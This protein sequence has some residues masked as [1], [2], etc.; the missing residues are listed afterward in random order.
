MQSQLSAAAADN[1]RLAQEGA[2]AVR[3]LAAA[4]DVLQGGQQREQQLAA[5]LAAAVAQC[6]GV[7]RELAGLAGKLEA[8]TAQC[9]E[10]RCGLQHGCWR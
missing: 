3:Q 6:E 8:R 7:G 5:S 4:A 10:L 9:Q 1:V 2:G